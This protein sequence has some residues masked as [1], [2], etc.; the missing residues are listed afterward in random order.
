MITMAKVSKKQ[1]EEVVAALK[2]K[3]PESEG[4]SHIDGPY[5]HDADHE[6]MRP[7][8]WSISWEGAPVDSWAVHISCD[9]EFRA[10]HPA[11]H[12]E[13]MYSWCLGLYPA[14]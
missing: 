12:F 13:A 4:Y 8:C 6:E 2:A 14:N 10:K 7:G 9:E 1:A 5:L 3:W 11:I